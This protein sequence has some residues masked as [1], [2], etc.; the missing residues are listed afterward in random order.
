MPVLRTVCRYAAGAALV[1]LLGLGVI[2][3][4]IV[5]TGRLDQRAPAD[6]IVV[7]GAA[8]YDGTPSAVYA[9][10]LDHAAELFRAGT[11]RHVL[12]IGGGRPGDR[13]SEGEAGRRYLT[14]AGLPEDAVIAVGEGH[15]TLVSLRAADAVLRAHGWSSVV[16]V[17][18]PWH[19]QRS[20]LM[21]TDL[22]LHCQVSPVAAGPAAGRGIETRY[23]VRETVGTLFYLL[24]GGSSGLG[25]A[26]A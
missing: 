4:R 9:A 8:Q 7:L 3:L 26:V 15:D 2:A 17:T 12:A 24:T 1:L 25:P 6:A 14:R 21:A 13:V 16:L 23:V 5:Q 20:R 19:S 18:D 22:G 10:R 11:A